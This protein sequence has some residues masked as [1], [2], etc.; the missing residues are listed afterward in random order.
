MSRVEHGGHAE[1]M[2][3]VRL[4]PFSVLRPKRCVHSSSSS[5]PIAKKG[6]AASR[7][8]TARRR[9]TRSPRAPRG[10][11]R[12]P[13][14][15][16]T[17][18]RRPA[19]GG[20]RGL[21]R[22]DVRPRDVVCQL[23]KRRKSRQM[24]L[25]RHLRRARSPLRSVTFQPLWR[26]I[27]STNA[28]TARAATARS[29]TPDSS[30]TRRAPAPAARRPPA[31]P[32]SAADAERAGR[33]PPGASAVAGH[34]RRE[35]GVHARLDL[36]HAAEARVQVQQ[37]RAARP[38]ARR[39]RDRCRRRRGGSGR[40]TA[41]DRRRGT[42]CR[43][44]AGRWRQSVSPASSAASSSRISACS[45]S[46]SWNSSTKMCLKRAWK[47]RRTSGCR[48]PGRAR[49]AAGRGSRARRRAPSAPRSDRWRRAARAAAAPRD[50]RPRP[51]GTDRAAT[52]V[53]RPR[54]ARGRAA[55]RPCTMAPRPCRSCRAPDPATGR[56]APLP[57]RRSRQRR[58]SPNSAA[59]RSRR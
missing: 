41:W 19:R 1:R 29:P 33:S 53:R 54:S 28:P 16:G 27:Q 55:R 31:D 37:A 42:A 34:H 18:C 26:R 49:R 5:S 13:R 58:R 44:L 10:S 11:P 8:P 50:R 22:V 24:C 12:P 43:A 20:C 56:R 23:M 47:P 40:S 3:R 51:A 2:E 32:G 36:R 17:P 45:G 25:A 21:E 6:P 15:R 4:K 35:R 30:A 52:A 57:S 48:A 14:A 46:V 9:A 39:P 7:T 38:A 59:A